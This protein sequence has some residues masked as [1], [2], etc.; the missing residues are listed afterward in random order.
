[1]FGSAFIPSQRNIT[2]ATK[3]A[4]ATR[5]RKIENELWSSLPLF[6]AKIANIMQTPKE[7]DDL[8]NVGYQLK[9]FIKTPMTRSRKPTNTGVISHLLFDI[10]TSKGLWC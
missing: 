1:L 4:T 3:D 7:I 8:P 2:K 10:F 6:E 9:M 5:I